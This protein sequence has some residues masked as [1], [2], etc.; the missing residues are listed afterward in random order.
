M[1][2][3]Y[4]KRGEMYL[5]FQNFQALENIHISETNDICKQKDLGK[6]IFSKVILNEILQDEESSCVFPEKN[7]KH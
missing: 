6:F 5:S 3:I 4:E 2:L 7:E 1:S